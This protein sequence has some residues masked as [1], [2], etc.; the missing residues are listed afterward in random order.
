MRLRLSFIRQTHQVSC[1]QRNP[2]GIARGIIV[3]S[4]ELGAQAIDDAG[5]R[6]PD[7]TPGGPD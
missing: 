2:A 1:N 7:R 3:V 6:Q 4:H 5:V